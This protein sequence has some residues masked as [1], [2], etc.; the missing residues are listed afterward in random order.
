MWHMY[1]RGM[2]IRSATV[3]SN[4]LVIVNHILKS[5][6]INRRAENHS[7][8]THKINVDCRYKNRLCL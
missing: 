8:L 7:G 3:M 2:L 4:F 1:E 5:V 6:I